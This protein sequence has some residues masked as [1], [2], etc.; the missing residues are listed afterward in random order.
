MNLVKHMG[1]YPESC[2]GLPSSHLYNSLLLKMVIEMVSFPITNGDVGQFFVSLPLVFYGIEP[3]IHHGKSS[4][5]RYVEI[6]G[7][8]KNPQNPYGTT[9]PGRGLAIG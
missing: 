6:G 4:D 5:L 8:E 7:P 1:L 3:P 2:R 9:F